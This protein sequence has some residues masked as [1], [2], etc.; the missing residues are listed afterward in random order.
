L[1]HLLL[2]SDQDLFFNFSFFL[3]YEMK[4]HFCLKLFLL[5]F[6][7]NRSLFRVDLVFE[8]REEGI[9]LGFSGIV[10]RF[11]GLQVF[12]RFPIFDQRG[13]YFLLQFISILLVGT[14]FVHIHDSSLFFE[15]V[16]FSFAV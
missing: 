1:H 9:N 3:S 15:V 6:I 14:L 8:F 11:Y 5:L 7:F 10:L 2:S 4:P 12:L 16:L 13:E